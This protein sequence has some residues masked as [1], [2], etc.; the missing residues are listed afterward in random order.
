MKIFS[1]L[2]KSHP[3]IFVRCTK[4]S[5]KYEDLNL[6]YHCMLRS[7]RN[8]VQRRLNNVCMSWCVLS[9]VKILLMLSCQALF[10]FSVL[11]SLSLSLSKGSCASSP[12][13]VTLGYVYFA[14]GNRR[15]NVLSLP[16]WWWRHQDLLPPKRLVLFFFK[17]WLVLSYLLYRGSP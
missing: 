2:R 15:E 6:K 17:V 16:R 13:H 7:S 8:T 1:K 12:L 5:Y 10:S 14:H 9:Q 3:I 11:L 4:V